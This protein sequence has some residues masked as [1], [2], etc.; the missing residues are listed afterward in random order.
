MA[1]IKSHLHTALSTQNTTEK[2]CIISHTQNTTALQP[3]EYFNC[4]T[5]AN[6]Q[7]QRTVDFP[8]D[9]QL[10]RSTASYTVGDIRTTQSETFH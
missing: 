10:T 2:E 6:G 1:T 5:S 3:S 9:K 7:K 4:N 8:Q